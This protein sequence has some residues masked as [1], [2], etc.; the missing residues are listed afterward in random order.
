[1]MELVG[2]RELGLYSTGESLYCG[3]LHIYATY[4]PYQKQYLGVWRADWVLG[5]PESTV[6]N[7]K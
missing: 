1:M 2:G 4:V 7:I 6:N 5:A 3:M